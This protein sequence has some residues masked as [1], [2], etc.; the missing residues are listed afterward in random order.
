[1]IMKVVIATNNSGKYLELKDLLA[2]S[3]IEYVSLADYDIADIEE[4]G[5][6]YLENA[7]IKAR[8]VAKLTGLPSVGDDSGLEIAALEGYP[9]IKSARCAGEGASDV[10]KREHILS[11]MYKS[12]D[13]NARFICTLAF[14]HPDHLSLPTVFTGIAKGIIISKPVGDAD[15]GLQYDSIFFYPPIGTTFANTPKWLKNRV[16]H[17]AKASAMMAKY[18]D[19]VLKEEFN[20]FG[21]Q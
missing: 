11:L 19:G 4:P 6:T 21:N 16:S 3:G 7:I 17:R 8:T 9:G 5:Q 18:L 20:G 12:T 2:V 13:D 15:K 14:V 1:M 10:E